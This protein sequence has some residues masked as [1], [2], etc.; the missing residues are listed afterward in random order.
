MK[1]AGISHNL[2]PSLK[3]KPDPVQELAKEVASA[4]TMEEIQNIAGKA[5]LFMAKLADDHDLSTTGFMAVAALISARSLNA[6]INEAA[7]E[8]DAT[9][10]ETRFDAFTEVNEY[11]TLHSLFMDGVFKVDFTWKEAAP[12]DP[13]HDEGYIIHTAEVVRDGDDDL[14]SLDATSP[15]SEGNAW[16]WS[17]GFDTGEHDEIGVDAHA[18]GFADTEEEAKAACEAVAKYCLIIPPG[19]LDPEYATRVGE[20]A[21]LSLRQSSTAT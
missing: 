2:A 20:Q 19:G 9:E 17:V 5:G 8:G 18:D 4:S 15:G 16:S 7:E 11:L 6:A 10:I 3:V 21:I 12:G 1:K 14:I 13:E